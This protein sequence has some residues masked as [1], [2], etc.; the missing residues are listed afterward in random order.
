MQ[1]D[2][3]A[4]YTQQLEFQGWDYYVLGSPH[5]SPNAEVSIPPIKWAGPRTRVASIRAFLRLVDPAQLVVVT[6]A[7]FNRTFSRAPHASMGC[8]VLQHLEFF[9][10]L[11]PIC[12]QTLL[13]GVTNVLVLDQPSSFAERFD[14]LQVS[15]PQPFCPAH[16]V[17]VWKNPLPLA[18]STSCVSPP[19]PLF[20]SGSC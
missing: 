19:G 20:L 13:S 4:A 7:M 3:L 2:G 8:G 18:L 10:T 9:T 15:C 1:V 17:V 14:A 16:A 12:S 5:L 11:N 6:G